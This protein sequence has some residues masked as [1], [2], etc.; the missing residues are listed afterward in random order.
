MP[1]HHLVRIGVMGHV[2]RFDSVDGFVYARHARVIC[3]TA[4]GLEVGEVLSSSESNGREV[5]GT[6]LRR[7]TTEDDLL[8][9]RIEQN[10]D[11]AFHACNNLLAE[12]HLPAVLMDVE[13]LFDG[14][15]LYFYFLGDVSPEIEALT[16]ELASTYE[17]EV[18]FHKFAETLSAGCGPGCGTDEATGQGCST[19]GCASCAVASACGSRGAAG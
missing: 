17:T 8:L 6:L 2:G 10:R 4:R 5:D 9:T 15:S 3:R 13:H 1:A 18:Q 19:G 14:Q 11:E 7:L 12:R 16:S